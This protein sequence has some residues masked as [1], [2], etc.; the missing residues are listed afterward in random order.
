MKV[1]PTSSSLNTK[2]LP[3]GIKDTSC[4][5]DELKNFSFLILHGKEKGRMS[6]LIPMYMDAFSFQQVYLIL[7]TCPYYFNSFYAG[8]LHLGALKG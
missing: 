4:K 6:L 7:A 1:E 2:S 3:G 8:H 5:G